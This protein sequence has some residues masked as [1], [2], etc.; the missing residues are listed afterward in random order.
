MT[1]VLKEKTVAPTYQAYT[2]H[3]YQTIPQLAKLSEEDRF[4]IEVVGNVLPFRV[5]QYVIDELIDWEQ[6]PQDPLFTMTFPRREML[7]SHDFAEVAGLLRQGADREEVQA[8]AHRIRGQLNPHPAGQMEHNVPTLHGEKLPGMQHKYRETVLFFPSQG[9]TCHAYCTYCFRWA[10]FVGVREL[11]FAMRETEKLV[12]YLRLHPE[13]SD[14]LFTGGDP[15]VMRAKHLAAYV[16]P[17]LA[18]DL[19]GLR[20]IRIGTKSL[21]YWPYRYLTDPDADEVLT[22]FERVVRSGKNLAVMA[23]FSH[24]RELETEAVVKAVRRIRA[25]GAQIRTQS[26]VLRHINDDGDL[27][28][29]M[30]RQQVNLGMTPYYMFVVRDT[31]AQ[32]YFGL[33]LVRAWEIYRQ[34]YSQVSG[35]ARTVRGPS[36]SAGPGKVQILGVS[37][38]RG[39]PVFCLRFLQGRN[40][41]W[42]QRPFFA[43]FNPEAQWLDE[44]EPAFGK[45]RFFFEEEPDAPVEVPHRPL[46]QHPQV[47]RALDEAAD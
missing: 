9:Q 41:D 6:A 42:V 19:P 7:L 4:A 11:K 45:A 35:L 12:E 28:S 24:P 47:R 38:V 33:P 5:N 14:V 40:P 44:L 30:W 15:M 23:H 10:Q 36:M 34:A 43:R 32:H 26:P 13:V 8:A 29:E 3:N 31:G 16:E 39:H 20:S 22:L 21:S 27:W 18:A 25:T 17:L 2:L 37:Q 46:A 1:T